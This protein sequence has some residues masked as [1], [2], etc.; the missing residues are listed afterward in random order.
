MVSNPSFERRFESRN[1]PRPPA[2]LPLSRPVPNTAPLLKDN[3]EKGILAESLGMK[4]TFQCYKC[5][6]FGHKAANCGN[7][8]LFFN[9]QGQNYE[10][11]DIEEQLYEPDLKNLPES[12]EDCEGREVT[13]GVVRYALTQAKEDNNWRRNAIF[14]TYIKCGEKDCKV[15]IDSGSC[16]N[17]VS[18]STVS[19]LG[20]KLVPHP[21]VAHETSIESQDT[22]PEEVTSIP[23]EFHEVFPVDL[24]D[25]LPPM[26]DIQCDDSGAS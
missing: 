17:A 20:L 19:R 8:T 7:R 12:D 23:Q 21:I 6:G 14:Y 2:T 16:I 18:S 24:P 4:F 11:D 25:N 26:Y 3:K 22:P 9:S 13:L 1:T 15:I 5:Q 10:G